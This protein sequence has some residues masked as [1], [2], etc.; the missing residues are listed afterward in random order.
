MNE[1]GGNDFD[2]RVSLC[3]P[4]FSIFFSGSLSDAWVWGGVFLFIGR[5]WIGVDTKAHECARIMTVPRWSPTQTLPFFCQI[6]VMSVLSCVAL[7]ACVLPATQRG[8]VV[9]KSQR[10]TRVPSLPSLPMHWKS[11]SPATRCIAQ[12]K[13]PG[14]HLLT[15]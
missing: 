11:T 15:R 10:S 8:G 13:E 14:L 2:L 4:F 1:L 5:G 9:M 3:L 12:G 7:H 6:P